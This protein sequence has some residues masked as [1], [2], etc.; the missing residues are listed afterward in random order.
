[1]RNTLTDLCILLAPQVQTEEEK[2]ILERNK[3]IIECVER[4]LSEKDIGAFMDVQTELSM[5]REETAFAMGF[6]L[7]VRVLTAAWQ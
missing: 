3:E 2:L 5:Y 4:Q 1:M 6:Q 7:A